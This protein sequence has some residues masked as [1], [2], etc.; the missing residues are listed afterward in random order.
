MHE[1]RISIGEVERITGLSK[2]LLRTWERRY[3]FP[4]PVRSEHDEREYSREDLDRLVRIAMLRNQ[5]P[6]RPC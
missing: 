6:S 4:T 3:G 1:G 2:D 5:S